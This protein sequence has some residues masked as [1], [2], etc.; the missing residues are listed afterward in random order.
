NTTNVAF[1]DQNA[2]Y[3]TFALPSL[4]F[5]SMILTGRY[6]HARYM[7]FTTY[8]GQTQ[9]IDNIH[10]VNIVP[11]SGIASDNPFIA[12][13]ARN[14]E[15]TPRDY[16]VTVLKKQKP[17]S[18]L[19]NTIYTT[20]FDG[21]HSNLAT[22]IVIYRT[23]RPDKAYPNDGGGGEG[24]P[25]ITL[26]PTAG[27]S[28]E[29]DSSACSTAPDPNNGISDTLANTSLP[30]LPIGP[31][32]CYPG[33][34]PPA[35][36]RFTNI[37]TAEVQGT[38]NTCLMDNNPQNSLTGP[39]DTN[40]PN[41]GFLENP[42]NKYIAAILNV[43]NFP[44]P[45]QPN[46][47]L[48]R[49]RVPTTPDTYPNTPVMPGGQLRY[50][51]MCSNEGLSTRFYACVMDDGLARLNSAGDYCLAVSR[52]ADRPR[53]ANVKHNVNWLPF[54]V[55][56]D[57]VLIER[58]MLPDAGFGPAI[59]NVAPGNEKALGIYFPTSTY[60]TVADFE[61]KGCPGFTNSTAF[62]TQPGDLPAT[63]LPNTSGPGPIAALVAL[64]GLGLVLI[65]AGGVAR[66]RARVVRMS[67]A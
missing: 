30:S 13:N 64:A 49:S 2:N 60:M 12:G 18:P 40:I 9:A 29:L 26:Y 33:L 32:N 5:D 58:N 54:G 55:L 62:G 46:V 52:T 25:T 67:Q 42:D 1:P 56:H 51:S 11:K 10:D 8:T 38:N 21:S 47:L 39:L 23:Y 37:A 31:L 57:N 43:D 65:L 61:A 41:G 59:Q 16:Q 35:W 4:D 53:N 66:I 36:H 34:N 19:P 27:P 50:W 20:D 22:F 24:L 6:P 48:V 7:S 3:F 63:V 17:A 15:G 28:I 44:S 45:G 14:T